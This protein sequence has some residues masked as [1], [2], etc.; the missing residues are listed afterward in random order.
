MALQVYSDL[1]FLTLGA[2][3][4]AGQTTVT[5]AT[6]DGAKCP[7]TGEF[8]VSMTV[9]LATKTFNI[10]KV[11]SRAGDVLTGTGGASGSTDANVA[12]GSAAIGSVWCGSM[13]DGVRADLS[14]VGAA[15][16]LP[17][18]TNQKTGNRYNANDTPEQWVLSGGVWVKVTGYAPFGRI[19]PFQEPDN[20]A[21]A[22]VNQ[23]TSLVTVP[24]TPGPIL[25]RSVSSG[26][27]QQ[28]C[29]VRAYPGTP[30]TL[31]ARLVPQDW[32]WGNFQNAGICIV[33]SGAT[34]PVLQFCVAC[35][36]GNF[37]KVY[38][39]ATPT[40]S[41]N[42]V[43]STAIPQAGAGTGPLFPQFFR[44]VDN[45]TNIIFSISW[46]G[47]IY[48]QIYSAGRTSFLTP[49]RIGISMNALSAATATSFI[50]ESWKVS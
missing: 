17:S 1:A 47:S 23:S 12:N 34:P 36:N 27:D 4:T 50:L 7:A 6:G 29:Y 5:L 19:I 37:V 35:Q 48:T 9:N 16:S 11:T 44:I 18:T 22:F 20:S 15:A 42:T 49:N 13:L 32:I 28:M 26:T 33:G 38:S 3:Y 43:T 2:A 21:Y 39:W 41:P 25:F 40:T 46:D 14:Q 10:F 24:V 30:F 45:G 31:D 8:Y